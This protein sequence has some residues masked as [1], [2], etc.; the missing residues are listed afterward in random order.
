MK[1]FV[2]AAICTL[3]LVGFVTADEFFGQITKV[4]GNKLT[5]M[6]GKKGDDQKEMTAEATKDVKVLTGMFDKDAGGFKA[7]DP[8]EG[9]LKNDMFAKIAD[10]KGP[11]AQ[12]TTN[13]KGQVTQILAFKGFGKKK[14]GQ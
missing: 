10:G 12:I 13:D 3:T 1:K 14:G 6:K 4:D 2:M 5:I 11:F 9:G 8:I 7:G